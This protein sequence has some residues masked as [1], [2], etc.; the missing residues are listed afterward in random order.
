MLVHYIWVGNKEIPSRYIKNY[1]KCIKI[2]PE[3]SFRVWKNDECLAILADNNLLDYWSTLTFVCKCNLL[4]YLILD[5]FGGIYSDFDIS[6]NMPFNKILNEVLYYN[7]DLV[8][9]AFHDNP[10]LV[11]DKIVYLLDDP[12]IYSKPN[13]LGSCIKF[14]MERVKLKHDGDT[15]MKTK[16][17]SPN[18]L[19]PIGP[20]GLTEWA[21]ILEIN[22]NYFFQ[23]TLLDKKSGVFGFHE[24][25]TNWSK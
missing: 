23:D 2:N 19:E 17:F 8:L 24:Q 18:R 21:H 1:E 6:W 3:F 10:I 7:F 9:P 25:N 22:F 14:C 12:F 15:Y 4:K 16:Q 5:K 20:F 13:I 11:R